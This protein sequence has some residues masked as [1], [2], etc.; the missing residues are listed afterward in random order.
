MQL[1][2]LDKDFL[3]ILKLYQKV[4]LKTLKKDTGD[5]SDILIRDRIKTRINKYYTQKFIE[6]FSDKK[7]I[8]NGKPITL[9]PKNIINKVKNYFNNPS[10]SKWCIVSQCDP[11]DLKH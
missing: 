11:N 8:L 1:K 10:K 3:P 5:S 7:V 6:S 2:K 9:N 4:F